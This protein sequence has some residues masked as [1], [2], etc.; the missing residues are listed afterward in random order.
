MAL[1]PV[2]CT[3]LPKVPRSLAM[4]SKLKRLPYYRQLLQGLRSLVRQSPQQK[5]F[6][7]WY[8]KHGSWIP[9]FRNRYFGQDCF[10]LANG[11][12]LNAVDLKRVNNFHLIGLNKVHLLLERA[13]L[14]L[15]FHV[16][17]NNLVIEQAWR[18]FTLL[19][20]PSFLSYQPA[21]TC[22]RGDSNIR[23][24]LTEQMPVPRFSR[25]YDE[26]IWEGWT[27]TYAALQLAYFMGFKNIFLVG[28]DHNF[29]V[30][31]S[32][33]EE[34]AMQGADPNH[35]DPRYFAGSRWHLPDLEGSEMAYEV[36]R[37]AFERSGRSIYDATEKGHCRI[38]PRISLE[39][40]YSRAAP[41]A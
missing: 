9:E 8:A 12:S 30:S 6:L 23:Y 20:C 17:I 38:F 3:I 19:N 14:D 16:A 33:N 4:I 11:P 28:L 1:L 32:P 25:V 29:K 36:A 13:K 37:F 7:L 39:E 35:F 18:E 40:A 22:V 10:L 15:T 41:R 34:Q 24:C 26:P 5:E 27:V 31:G 21:S 2:D